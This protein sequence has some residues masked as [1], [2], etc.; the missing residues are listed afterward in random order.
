MSRTKFIQ[1][2]ALAATF[3]TLGS[4]LFPETLLVQSIVESANTAGVPGESSLAKKYNNYFG[5][6]AAG[7]WTG[8]SV[9]LR[10]GEY[11]G[12]VKTTITDAFRVY[13]SYYASVRDVIKFYKTYSRYNMVLQAEDVEAQLRAIGLSG[14]ATAPNYGA[15]LISVYR[16]NK[17]TLDQ[18]VLM[19]KFK[20]FGLTGA[21]TLGTWYLINNPPAFLKK[22]RAG[23]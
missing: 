1:A 12:G 7:N 23:S 21:I 8:K 10:T 15:T 19:A 3:A 16:A 13:P 20:I 4:P 2:H 6:K 22:Y 11:F 14:Y 18:S 9:S 17:D 5:I